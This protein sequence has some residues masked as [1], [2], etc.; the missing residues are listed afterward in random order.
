MSES[1]K[2]I[3]SYFEFSNAGIEVVEDGLKEMTFGEFLVENQ[4]INRY[5]LLCGL[6]MQDE[7]PGVRIGECL[8]ALGFV[9]Y[10]TI[11]DHLS[12]WKQI[13]VIEA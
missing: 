13:E 9:P 7:H 3:K 5:Q 6:Q 8:A 10:T 11:E 4:A 2:E 12:S 1:K